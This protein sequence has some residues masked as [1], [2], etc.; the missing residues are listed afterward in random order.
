MQCQKKVLTVS[1]KVLSMP[2]GVQLV[3]R[4]EV[5]EVLMQKVC[6]KELC[7]ALSVDPECR[8]LEWKESAYPLLQSMFAVKSPSHVVH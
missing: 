8:L 5:S 7:L 6:C 1:P 2:S 4:S 3:C